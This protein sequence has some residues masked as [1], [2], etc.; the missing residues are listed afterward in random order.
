[1]IPIRNVYYLLCYAWDSVDEARALGPAGSEDFHRVQDLFGAILARGV[2]RV[3]RKGLDRSYVSFQEELPGVRGKLEMTQT[4]KQTSL[5]RNRIVCTFDDLSTDVIHNQVVASTL[6]LLAGHQDVDQEVKR[7]LRLALSRMP[8][9]SIRPI[10]RQVFARIH[11][12]RNRREYRFLIHLCGLLHEVRLVDPGSGE[13]RFVEIDQ[14]RLRMWQVFERFVTRF[15][16]REQTAFKVKPQSRVEWSSLRSVG[17][18]SEGRIPKMRPDVVLLSSNRR[19]VLDAKY[20][21]S[22]G[23]GDEDGAKL[24]SFHLYQLFAYVMNREANEPEGARHEGILLYPTVGE[25]TRVEFWSHG[26]RF[27]ARSVDLARP[28]RA[29]HEQLLGVLA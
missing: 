17:P 9:V 18:A 27:Q 24:D 5:L 3:A 14:D 1:M 4:L 23:L 6:H 26:H 21:Q 11:L 29:I 10:T 19:V 28:W 15:Y 13:S 22:G 8:G 7:E 2:L 16:K 20:A 25:E 12:D